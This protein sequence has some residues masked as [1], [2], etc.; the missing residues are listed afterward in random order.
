MSWQLQ[1]PARLRHA[2][3]GQ[4]I[5]VER[6]R[7]QVVDVGA[8]EG[9]DVGDQAM[10]V[11]Q[12]LVHVGADIGLVVPTKCFEHFRD[13]ALC[14]RLVETAAALGLFREFDGAGG[15]DLARGQNNFGFGTQR[16]IGN[17]VE[18]EQR[19]EDA[20]RITLQRGVADRAEGGRMHGNASGREIV[21]AD[22]VHAH[23]GK[24][25]AHHSEFG[26]GA[27]PD[28]AVALL[29][30]AVERIRRVEALLQL[31]V[32]GERIV[33]DLGDQLHQR[34]VC[35][36]LFAVHD[37]HGC[38]KGRADVVDGYETILFHWGS[39]RAMGEGQGHSHFGSYPIELAIDRVASDYVDARAE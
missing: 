23:D 2:L 14:I 37:R 7:R 11:M 18:T 6:A 3:E 1:P 20:E 24:D 5:D 13:E 32:G 22:R 26:G 30:D 19:G 27:E 36:H 9:D 15:E 39:P 28:R 25:A 34:A 31:G 33:V 17:E 16:F 38:G 21:V 12:A 8:F 4:H 35:R 29:G 10:G